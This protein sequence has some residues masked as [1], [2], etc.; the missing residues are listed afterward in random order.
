MP[1]YFR[2]L[3]FNLCFQKSIHIA[4]GELSLGAR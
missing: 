3:F 1:R 4:K 2:F